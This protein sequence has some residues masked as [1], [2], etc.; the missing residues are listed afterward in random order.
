MTRIESLVSLMQSMTT[1]EKRQFSM[2]FPKGDFSKDYLIIYR[3]IERE[4]KLDPGKIKNLFF[5]NK[6]EGSFDTAI[7]YLYDKLLDLL[8]AVRKNKESFFLLFQDILKAKMLFE[9]SMFRECFVL[10]K[11]IIDEAKRLENYHALLLAS[12]LE[13][14]YLSRMNFL[15]V[16]EQEL[17][18]KQYAMGDVLKLIRTINAQSSLYELLKH[19]LIHKGNMRSDKQKQ[20]MNDLVVSELSIVA[21][22]KDTNFEIMKMHQL[23]QANYLISVGDYKAAFNSFKELTILFESNSHLWENPPFDYLSTLE[24]VL[25]GLRSVGNYEGMDYFLAQLRNL[26]KHSSLNFRVNAICLL[27]QYEL[28][29]L[30]D[31]GNFA[32]CKKLIERYKEVLYD[33]FSWLSP[34]RQSELCLY[35]SLIYLGNRQFKR[36][37]KFIA[38]NAFDRSLGELP[39]SRTIKLVRLMLYYEEGDFDVIQYETR[40]FKR[41]ISSQKDQTFQ[42][43]HRMLWFLNQNTLPTLQ[44]TRNELWSNIEPSIEALRYDKYESQVLRLFDFTAWMESKILKK[45]LSD[46]LGRKFTTL[47]HLNPLS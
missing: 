16:T 37:K 15:D 27:F 11:E 42:I 1:A 47:H 21:S 25:E 34:I 31:R 36:A 24:G 45:N 10:L 29:P 43:E 35:T 32:D 30:L 23:F 2:N 20:E 44:R 9:R 12:K 28:I 7:K 13:L 17:F 4:K 19:R 33:K 6:P 3:I 5:L 38:N 22:S 41:G 18:H 40:S 46:I 14:D 39:L 26:T 8:L